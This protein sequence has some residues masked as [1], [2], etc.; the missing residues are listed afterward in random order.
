ME[1][2]ELQLEISI[3][4]LYFYPNRRVLKV[5]NRYCWLCYFEHLEI[6]LSQGSS[7]GLHTAERVPVI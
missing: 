6:K 1:T 3:P 2:E 4:A 7:K 5:E